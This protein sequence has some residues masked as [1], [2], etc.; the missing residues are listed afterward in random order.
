MWGVVPLQISEEDT[1]EALFAEA[2]GSA[3]KAGLIRTGDTV[4]LTAGVPLGISG[5]TNMVRVETV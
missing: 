1:T 4:V 2:I 5:R 3:K